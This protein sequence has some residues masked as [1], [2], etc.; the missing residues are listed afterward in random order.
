M[1]KLAFLLLLILF[2]AMNVLSQSGESVLVKTGRNYTLNNQKISKSK[3]T[4][5]YSTYPEALEEYK[6]GKTYKTSGNV[7]AFGGLSY[8]LV[9]SQVVRIQR[10]N[11]YTDWFN[12]HSSNHIAGTF[13]DSKYAD[14]LVVNAVIGVGI[15]AIGAVCLIAAP[16]HFNKAVKLYN[17]KNGNLGSIPVQLNLLLG[18]NGIGVKM[19]F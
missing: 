8:V 2:F 11:D 18:S 12:Y 4:E 1:K 6:L 15:S 7:L 9:S 3:L 14:K 5:I 17:T 13:D 10:E 16:G 19:S